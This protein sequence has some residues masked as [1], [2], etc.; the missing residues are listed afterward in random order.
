MSSPKPP[1][2]T[3]PAESRHLKD[4]IFAVAK[5]RGVV[6][7]EL[8]FRLEHEIPV[9]RFRTNERNLIGCA[10]RIPGGPTSAQ[11]VI[12]V[13]GPSRQWSR[14]WP[15]KVDGGFDI[16]AVVDF[17]VAL[18]SHEHAKPLPPP[19]QVPSRLPAACS[20]L[21]VVHLAAVRL[22]VLP[23]SSNPEVLVD[24]IENDRIRARIKTRMLKGGLHEGDLR[25][26]ADVA[27]LSLWRPNKWDGDP[28]EPFSDRILP[29]AV[30]GKA[31]DAGI[32][33][34][35]LL[36]VEH[37][38]TEI[39]VADPAG[40]GLAIIG[41]GELLEWCKLGAKRGLPWVGLVGTVS[42]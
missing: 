1:L 12:T 22:G 18:V 16:S 9:V 38:Q 19:L 24:G 11:K 29:L 4:I 7:R 32:E 35:Y 14:S 20:G 40:Y 17:L 41:S 3:I 28:F 34:R 15:R 33:R 27:A 8:S 2:G 5:A 26:L 30:V 36:V 21:H 25:I 10:I 39:L 31:T 6:L 23:A 37:A 13:S 42:E